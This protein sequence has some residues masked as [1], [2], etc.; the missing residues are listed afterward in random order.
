LKCTHSPALRTRG[1]GTRPDH[2]ISGTGAA[3]KA[4]LFG[5]LFVRTSWLRLRPLA[6]WSYAKWVMLALTPWVNHGWHVTLYV[7]ARGLGTSPIQIKN[8]ILEIEFDFISHRLIVRTSWG[9]ERVLPL[10]PQTV[11]DF[12]HRVLDLLNGIGIAV[13]INEMPN[14]MQNPIRFSDDLIHGP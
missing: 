6:R 9:A 7:T 4:H 10:E 12:Y 11:A 2:P 5:P 3:R 13:S 1:A 14:E 8:E